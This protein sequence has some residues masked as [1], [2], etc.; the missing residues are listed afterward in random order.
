MGVTKCLGE[1]VNYGRG[2][3]TKN[4]VNIMTVELWRRVWKGIKK[5][6]LDVADKKVGE[7]GTHLCAHRYT[8]FLAI[9]GVVELEGV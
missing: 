3:K 2:A 7:R 8:T 6:V 5:R 1:A 4:I 9:E